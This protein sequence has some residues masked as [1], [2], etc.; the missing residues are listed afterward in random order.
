MNKQRSDLVSKKLGGLLLQGYRMLNE[1]CETCD[2]ILMQ[3]KNEPKYCVGCKDE[4][5]LKLTPKVEESIVE[6][7]MQF[8]QTKPVMLVNSNKTNNARD[9]LKTKINWA[10]NEINST[11]NVRANIEYI[12]MII[13]A[14]EAIQSLEKIQF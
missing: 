2:V 1:T 6:E 11:T 3:R 13:K 7:E 14:A 4:D 5:I 9:I 10:L 12:E 8:Q